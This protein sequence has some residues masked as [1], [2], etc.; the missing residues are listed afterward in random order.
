MPTTLFGVMFELNLEMAMTQIIK[1][2]TKCIKPH[3]IE[4]IL[5]NIEFKKKRRKMKNIMGFFIKF[6]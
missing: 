4:P 3:V 1:Y 5:S 6:S 2:R